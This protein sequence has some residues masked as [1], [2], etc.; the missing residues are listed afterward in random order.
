MKGTIYLLLS[1]AI[2][3]FALIAQKEGMDSLD[4]FSFT[5]IRCFLGAVSMFPLILWRTKQLRAKAEASKALATSGET[6]LS[7]EARIS[8]ELEVVPERMYWRAALPCGIFLTCLILFQQFGIPYTTVGKAA[9]ITALYIPI[10]PLLER[11]SGK[12]ISRRVWLSVAVTMV[13]VYLL[14]FTDGLS[15]FGFGDLC[16]VGAAVMASLQ[17]LAVDKWAHRVDPVKLS[18]YQFVIVGLICLPLML[19]FSDVTFAAIKASLIPLLYAGIF[20]CGLGYTFQ[21]VGQRYAPPARAAILM[22]TET[23]FSLIAGMIFYQEI[24]SLVEYLGC[25]IMFAGVVLSQKE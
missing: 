4:A 15:G 14:C 19:I 2:W 1:A 24:M 12:R 17:V 6:G 13:G 22:S 8:P 18:Y 7:G 23:V 3:G 9:F 20:S 10:I 11:L 16:M 5:T 21:V 25:A